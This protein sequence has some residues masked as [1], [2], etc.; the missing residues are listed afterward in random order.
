LRQCIIEGNELDM[1]ERGDCLCRQ[2]PT[3]W[4]APRS[5]DRCG[6]FGQNEVRHNNRALLLVKHL[7][8]I[9]TDGVKRISRVSV[10]S[11]DVCI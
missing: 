1:L 4:V 2:S 11:E 3:D 9:A 8:E 7:Q 5:A 6:N 10:T